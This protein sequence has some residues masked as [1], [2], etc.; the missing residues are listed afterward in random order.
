[1]T[2]ASIIALSNLRRIRALRADLLEARLAGRSAEVRSAAQAHQA[3][4]DAVT[5]V[6]RRHEQ[7]GR[8]VDALGRRQSAG[9]GL[10]QGADAYRQAISWSVRAAEIEA[11]DRAAALQAAE[12]AA[13]EVR[14][15]VRVMWERRDA[16]DQALR[17]RR[18]RERLRRIESDEREREASTRRR[19]MFRDAGGR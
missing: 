11:A 14:Q 2:D 3:A 7:A 18:A 10:L 17:G 1:M 5:L 4:R 6:A 8:D 13:A 9:A 19:F 16:L 15:A 12:A